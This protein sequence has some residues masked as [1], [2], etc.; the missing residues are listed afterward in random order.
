M[1]DLALKEMS[2]NDS[3]LPKYKSMSFMTDLDTESILSCNRSGS[4][5]TL[6]N[7]ISKTRLNKND[8]NLLNE[9]KSI[10]EKIHKRS[11]FTDDF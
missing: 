5:A 4:V 2:T 10:E 6:Q 7:N 1:V 8:S 9:S 11:F 3:S